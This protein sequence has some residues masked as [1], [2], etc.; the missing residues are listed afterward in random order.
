MLHACVAH[1]HPHAHA[2][3][4]PEGE[5]GGGSGHLAFERLEQSICQPLSCA[6]HAR[7]TAGPGGPPPPYAGWGW[8]AGARH[9]PAAPSPRPTPR[10]APAAPAL[11]YAFTVALLLGL[12]SFYAYFFWQVGGGG[13]PLKP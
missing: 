13:D 8:S 10:P 9:G 3:A 1:P 2:H 7:L 12:A 4:H 11:H 5:G 6:S